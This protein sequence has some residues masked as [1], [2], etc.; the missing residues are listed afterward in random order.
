MKISFDVLELLNHRTNGR[1]TTQAIGS[2]WNQEFYETEMTGEKMV[3]SHR[4]L[5]S[6]KPRF[7]V[8]YRYWHWQNE[9]NDYSLAKYPYNQDF[10]NLMIL[11]SRELKQYQ[12]FS[13]AEGHVKST[14][15]II[16]WLE[17]LL[18]YMDMKHAELQS[19]VSFELLFFVMLAV[20]VR[21]IFLVVPSPS[22]FRLNIRASL[23]H[24]WTGRWPSV[25]WR[26][27]WLT[28]YSLRT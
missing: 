26:G 27:V 7:R 11:N 4:S 9:I 3:T 20:S 6:D 17:R 5:R 14:A 18:T 16:Y 25:V 19:R 21:V 13:L 8:T 12:K 10:H 28:L 23:G 15:M 22:K 2:G 24:L 1:C